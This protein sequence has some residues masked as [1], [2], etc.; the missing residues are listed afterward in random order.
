MPFAKE[1]RRLMQLPDVGEVM[2]D[3]KVERSDVTHHPIG[4]SR[5]EYPV[6]LVLSGKGGVHGAKRAVRSLAQRKRTTFSG[7]GNAYQCRIGRI[8]V[9]SLGD[10]RYAVHAQGIGVGFDLERELAQVLA[11]VTERRLP[12]KTE[13]ERRATLDAYIREYK[14]DVKRKTSRLPGA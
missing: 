12:T 9:E 13:A 1:F 14:L 4:A 3:F 7:Y 11:F 6:E 8:E 10:R 5:Y 2:D